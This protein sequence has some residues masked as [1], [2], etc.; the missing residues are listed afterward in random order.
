MFDHFYFLRMLSVSFIYCLNSIYDDVLYYFSRMQEVF[1]FF[2]EKKKKINHFCY[3]FLHIPSI[4]FC[5]Y[6]I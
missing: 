2:R 4:D 1:L 3:N 5:V 6:Y